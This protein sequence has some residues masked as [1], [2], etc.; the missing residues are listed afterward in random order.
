MYALRY[1]PWMDVLKF[2]GIVITV[3]HQPQVLLRRSIPGFHSTCKI[4][5]AERQVDVLAML[6]LNLLPADIGNWKL[7]QWLFPP[8]LATK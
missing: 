4:A 6:L 7:Y 2:Q 5:E 8:S 1:Q 3:T